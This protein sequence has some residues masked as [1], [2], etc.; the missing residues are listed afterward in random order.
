MTSNTLAP[1]DNNRTFATTV[2]GNT[3]YTCTY[4]SQLVYDVMTGFLMV[5]VVIL[6]CTYLGTVVPTIYNIC[7][8]HYSECDTYTI[9]HA[10]NIIYTCFQHKEEACF[11][12]SYIPSVADV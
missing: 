8:F 2:T 11:L 12:H 9:V 10:S 5:S 3:V 7:N 6:K 1:H 4:Y